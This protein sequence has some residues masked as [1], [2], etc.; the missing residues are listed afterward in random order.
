MKKNFKNKKLIVFDIDGTLA[1]SKVPADREMIALLLRLLGA[2]KIA[3]IG[4]GK[5][6][7]FKKQLVRQLPKR[8]PRLEHLYLFP[9]NSTAFYRYHQGRSWY[10]VYSHELSRAERGK[11]KDAFAEVFRKT[12]YS[13]PPKTWGPV[14]EDRGTQITFSALGQEVVE[15][16]GKRGLKLKEEWNKH[17]DVRPQLTKVLIK[18]LPKFEVRLGGLTSIDIT[19][20]GIDKAYGIRQI[21]KKLH[22]TR[23]KIFFVGDAIFPGG[24]DYAVVRTGVDYIKVKDP[25]ETKKIIRKIIAAQD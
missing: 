9:T 6:D 2:K 5:Y 17:S 25:K 12:N 23:K 16:L 14:V 18:L 21:E 11:I 22:V 19:R 8:D 13:H 1:P 15:K 20:K 24:N 4:G 7:L 3:V 10:K